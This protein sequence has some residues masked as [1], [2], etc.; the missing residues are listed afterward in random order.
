MLD[1][2]SNKKKGMTYGEKALKY[3]SMVFTR[4][5]KSLVS[6]SGE[7]GEQT[8][9][10]WEWAKQRPILAH[11][12]SCSGLVHTVFL[13][14]KED[15]SF[16]FMGINYFRCFKMVG[17]QLKNREVK[18]AP[19]SK[20]DSKDYIESPQYVSHCLRHEESLILGTT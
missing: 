17:E 1:V 9:V 13:S 19:N 10:V 20:K 5:E 3:I 2:T 6:L 8:V 12:L 15:E 4:D 16:C 11:Q 7:V 18:E 14:P